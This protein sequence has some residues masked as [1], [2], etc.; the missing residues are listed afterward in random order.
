MGKTRVLIDTAAIGNGDSIASYL[1]DS[2]GT[3][4]TS[5]LVGADQS[6]DVNVTQS[7]L[8]AGAATETTLAS[9]LSEI[10]ALSHAED[11]AHVS[12]DIGIQM[13]VVRRDSA[14]ALAGSDGDY[15]PLQ[16]DANG[17][18]RITGTITELDNYAEDSVHSSGAM[19]EFILAV[20][21][22]S[23]SSLVSA[24]GDYAPFQVG[25]LGD[26]K[27]VDIQNSSLLQQVMTV[28]TTAIPLPASALPNRKKITLQMITG[29]VI[30]LGSATV[31]A[32]E[33]VTGGL[34]LRD[35][36]VFEASLG[37]AAAI[38]GIGSSAGRKVAVLEAA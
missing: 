16:V 28:D 23:S 14:G 3:L 34:Q 5:T 9:I 38:Y 18:L 25:S 26:L 6:L 30:Y 33:A 29:G 8:P 11:A 7:V 37:S 19:G 13:L 32:D 27:V 24:S 4:L 1:V 22:D 20:R 31:T 12:G 17:A 2:A 10:A 21:N 15:S 36:D 35:G